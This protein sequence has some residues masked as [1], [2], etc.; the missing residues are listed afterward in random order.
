MKLTIPLADLIALAAQ[1][2]DEDPN[3]LLSL[4]L[5]PPSEEDVAIPQLDDTSHSYDDGERMGIYY[6]LNK[7]VKDLSEDTL[8]QLR[9]EI[10][11][12]DPA[13]Q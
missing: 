12:T 9:R 7:F 11:L 4:A 8:R 3:D 2:I 1:Q 13:N 10:D 5:S 6:L